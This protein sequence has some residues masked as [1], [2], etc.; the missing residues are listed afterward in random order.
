MTQ[1]LVAAARGARPVREPRVSDWVDYV[2]GD[3]SVAAIEG[4]RLEPRAPGQT[5]LTVT[6]G[7]RSKKMRVIVHRLVASFTSLRNDETHVALALQLAQGDTSTFALP[8]G[9]YW[10]KSLP[11]VAGEAPPTITLAGGANGGT[12]DGLRDYRVVSDVVMTYCVVDRAGASVTV[13]HGTSGL[14]MVRGS[15]A[16][17]RVEQVT[18]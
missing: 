5:D 11:R 7:D 15:L 2:V 13:A 16:L 1:Y 3:T 18:K 14:P 8:P 9:V 6:V 12:G 17:D 10:L 4:T